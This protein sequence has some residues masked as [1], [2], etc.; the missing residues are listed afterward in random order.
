MNIGIVTVNY[1]SFNHLKNF[2]ESIKNAV[3]PYPYHIYVVDNNSQDGSKEHIK[4][5][6]YDNVSSVLLDKNIGY[7]SALNM[8]LKKITNKYDYIF[9]SNPDIKV[10][11]DT[12]LDMIEYAK[13][14]KDF[15]IIGPKLIYEDDIVQDSYRRFPNILDLVIK[16]TFLKKFFKKRMTR[17]LMWDKNPDKVEEV[18]WLVGA[19]WLLNPEA[20]KE[21]G[22]FD[23]RF[24]LFF[25]DVDLSRRIKNKGYK[26]I[27]FPKAIANH[28]HKRLSGGIGIIKIFTKKTVRIHIVSAL[29]YFIKYIK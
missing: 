28:Y 7:G 24:F 23:E 19:F 3:I 9:I 17:Y 14:N 10:K 12:I 21:A 1:N 2:I 6:K 11:K 4:N 15:G 22:C 5:M 18:D 8:I 25:E 27:Y 13:K 16:R 29:K 20:L 26:I